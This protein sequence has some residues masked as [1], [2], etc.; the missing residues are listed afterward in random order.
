MNQGPVK[1]Y[2]AAQCKEQYLKLMRII[3]THLPS[4]SSASQKQKM[5]L[6]TIA[7]GMHKSVFYNY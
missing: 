5:I 2:S 6:K 1:T 3:E 7:D 4:G